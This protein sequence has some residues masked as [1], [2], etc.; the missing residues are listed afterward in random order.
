MNIGASG[1]AASADAA[2]CVRPFV[3][4]VVVIFCLP[5]VLNCPTDFKVPSDVERPSE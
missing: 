4:P 5:I 2:V 3:V 1:Q